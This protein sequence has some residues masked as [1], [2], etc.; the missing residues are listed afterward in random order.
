MNW[1]FR[2]MYCRW[3]F[4]VVALAS[5]A[6]AREDYIGAAVIFIVG[7]TVSSIGM[8]KLP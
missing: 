6:F 3:D 7:V 4:F 8:K 1:F 5:M 2:P